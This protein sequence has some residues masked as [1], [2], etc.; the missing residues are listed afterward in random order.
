MVGFYKNLYTE[1]QL[2]IKRVSIWFGWSIVA[3]LAGFFVYPELLADIL[4]MF[5][6]RFGEN[7]ALSMDL[8]REIF[9]QNTVASMAALFGGLLLGTI[10]FLI[11]TINGFLIGYIVSSVVA[12]PDSNPFIGFIVIILGLAPHGIFELPA[13]LL[14]SAVGL[15]LG[16]S[17]LR[18]DAKGR[19]GQ[20][21]LGSLKNLL[22]TIPVVVFLLAIAALVEVFVTGNI[23]K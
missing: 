21:F 4:K 18:S 15:R 10:P 22:W 11:V 2:W 9:L 8:V 12:A 20:V 6:D 1:N 13:F 17:Y 7:P 14:A 5:Q 23:L 16:L 19:R 3:G